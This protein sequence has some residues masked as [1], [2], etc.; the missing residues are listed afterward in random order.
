MDDVERGIIAHYGYHDPIE[1][2]SPVAG[3]EDVLNWQQRIEHVHVEA[4]ILDYLMAIVNATRNSDYLELG[5]STRAAIELYKA[6]Q[7]RAYLNGRHYVTPD[8]I[9]AL[10]TSIFCHRVYLR[11]SYDGGTAQREQAAVV[12]AEL[13]ESIPVPR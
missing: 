8:D 10:V 7:A 1:S 3:F 5:V 11:Q 6:S 2:M 9:Q 12:L 4:A 13:V